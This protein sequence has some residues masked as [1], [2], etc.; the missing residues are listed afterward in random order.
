MSGPPP[1]LLVLTDRRLAA[2]RGRSVV[3]VAR[4]AL[5]AGAPAIVLREKDLPREQRRH[6]AGQLTAEAAATRGRLIVAS[7]AELAAE[8]GCEVVHLAVGDVVPDDGELR[9]GR[10]CHS[11]PEVERA[12]AEGAGYVLV[13]PVFATASKPGYGPPLGLDGLAHLVEAAGSL[14]VVALGGM[15]PERVPSCL[16]AGASG[17]AV[18]GAVMAAEDPGAVVSRILATLPA[19]S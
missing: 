7:D 19:G 2:S 10:S 8:M 6:L 16:A 12:G 18:M 1:R 4:A 9:W 17:V 13:S 3:D 14:P 5:R 15:T 11:R